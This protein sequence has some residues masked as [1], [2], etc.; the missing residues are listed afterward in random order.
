MNAR[1]QVAKQTPVITLWMMTSLTAVFQVY[2]W[3]DSEKQQQ[4]SLM[5]AASGS[6]MFKTGHKICVQKSHH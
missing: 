5:A 1:T 6:L 4:H 3:C 2:I